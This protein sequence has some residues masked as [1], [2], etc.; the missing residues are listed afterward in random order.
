MRF[1][2]DSRDKSNIRDAKAEA[3]QEKKYWSKKDVEEQVNVGDINTHVACD[4]NRSEKNYNLYKK[5]IT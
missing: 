3:K 5:K 2:A 4:T 1:N